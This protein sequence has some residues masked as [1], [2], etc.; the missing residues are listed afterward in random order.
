MNR[1]AL[2]RTV[3]TRGRVAWAEP[4]PPAACPNGHRLEPPTVR[5]GHQPCGCAPGGHRSFRCEVC[6][7]TI[8][9]PE[10]DGS[11]FGQGSLYG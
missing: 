7:S 4:P 3:D 9:R 6:G 1:M 8:Y 5:V 10:H 11:T 2:T